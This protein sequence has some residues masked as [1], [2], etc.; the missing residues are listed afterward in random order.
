MAAVPP[1]APAAAVRHSVIPRWL[2]HL[3]P[4]GLFAVAIFDSCIIPLPIPGSTDL[5]LLWLVSHRGEPW[6]LVACASAG[7]I[8]GGYTTWMSGHRGGEAAL[9]RYGHS[10]FFQRVSK[11]VENHSILSVFVPAVLP[12]PVPTS[13]FLI[14]AGALGISRGR[15]LAA[16][17]AARVLRY[18]LVAWLAVEYGRRIV[19]V[20]SGTLDKWEGPMV[21]TFTALLCGGSFYALWQF[22]KSRAATA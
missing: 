15:F 19:R 2:T 12:P 10:P 5:L 9:Q 8:I 14:A 7:S 18:S 21:W 3:G 16:Y 1:P 11:W 13:M 20:W 22:R 6:L 4:L 17:S